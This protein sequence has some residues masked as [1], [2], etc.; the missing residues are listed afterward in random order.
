MSKNTAGPGKPKVPA[1]QQ[2][3]V[4]RHYVSC[5]RNSAR[6]QRDHGHSER[7]VRRL[8]QQFSDDVDRLEIEQEDERR[9]DERDAQDRAREA[10]AEHDA[11]LAVLTPK[12]HAAVE[13]MLDSD[14]PADQERAIRYITNTGTK[15][16]PMPTEPDVRRRQEIR[17]LRDLDD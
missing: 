5:G 10:Q 8:V 4:V 2:L 12:V 15:V 7:N 14:N 17:R 9:Q 6:T 3:L 13:K 16:I 1:P 11:W